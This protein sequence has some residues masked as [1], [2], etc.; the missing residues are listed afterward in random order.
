MITWL[1][2]RYGTADVVHLIDRTVPHPGAGEVLIQMGAVGLN[3]ADVRIMRGEPLLVRLAFGL[4]R[5]KTPVPG[6][7][8][9]G[10]IIEEGEGV[11]LFAVGDRVVGELSTAGGLA[12]YVIAST[13]RL[14]PVPDEVD[15]L[16]AAALPMA[17]GTAW[18]ALDAAGVTAGSRVLVLGAGGGVG[19]YAV[20]L[21]VLRGAEVHALCSARA[22]EAVSGLGAASVADRA[23]GLDGLPTNSFDAVLDLGGRAPL[24]ALQRLVREGGT[25]VGI[26]VGENRVGPVGRMLAS[27]LRSIGSRR[28]IRPLTATAKPEI[29]AQLLALAASGDLV[30]VIDRIYPLD[31]AGAALTRIDGGGVVGKVLVR[32]ARADGD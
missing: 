25:V 19:T 5:P 24:A 30:P 18:Q 26:S 1:Q 8:V 10:T 2:D 7:D 9:A 15:D 31:D 6:R 28:R 17:G 23:A 11:E 20:R 29:T 14:V 13:D 16:T 22:I 3:S 12:E 4:R 32:A 21:A 27:A